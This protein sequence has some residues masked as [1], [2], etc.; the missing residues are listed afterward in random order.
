MLAKSWGRGNG[1][2]FM[3]ALV[4]SMVS[5]SLSLGERGGMDVGSHATDS[6]S[7]YS[8]LIPFSKG[9]VTCCIS[10]KPFLETL[11]CYFAF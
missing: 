5:I 10:L 3:I 11:H 9:F 1:I 7:S 4:C 8:G 2:V 6:Q